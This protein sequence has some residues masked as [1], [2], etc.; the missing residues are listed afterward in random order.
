MQ[1]SIESTQAKWHRLELERRRIR[2]KLFLDRC[3]AQA[4]QAKALLIIGPKGKNG[5]SMNAALLEKHG[6]K[7]GDQSS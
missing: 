2:K 5:R 3:A 7:K 6:I 4:K 1:D